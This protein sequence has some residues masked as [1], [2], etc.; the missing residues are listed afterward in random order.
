MVNGRIAAPDWV[1]SSAARGAKRKSFT[2]ELLEERFAFSVVP[3]GM[4]VTNYTSIRYAGRLARDLAERIRLGRRVQA[5]ANSSSIPVTTFAA[6]DRPLVRQSV[7]SAQY[8]SGRWSK[9]I[10]S[11]CMAL[12]ARTLMSYLCGIR[13]FTGD[14]IKV[15]RR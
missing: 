1:N 9:P 3:T 5:Q 4:Q 11:R 12:P 10:S 13:A 14:G 8:G 6:A 15:R 2:F 7:A